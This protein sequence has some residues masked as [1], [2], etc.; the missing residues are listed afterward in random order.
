[1]GAVYNWDW[2]AVVD[3]QIVTGRV[4]DDVPEFIDA[5]TVALLKLNP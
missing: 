1:M 5:V 2:S 4:P 3:G